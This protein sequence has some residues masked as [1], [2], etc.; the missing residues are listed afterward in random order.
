NPATVAEVFVPVARGRA[1]IPDET[2]MIA[3]CMQPWQQWPLLVDGRS[4]HELA[5]Y[6]L[7]RN[8]PVANTELEWITA[9][10]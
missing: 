6:D 9:K 4:Y 8:I 2:Y 3:T 1:D 10:R 7:A 5:K